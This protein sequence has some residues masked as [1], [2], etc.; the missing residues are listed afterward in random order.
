MVLIRHAEPVVDAHV[1][2]EFWELSGK[3]R[4]D[5]SR[6]ADVL[7]GANL[8]LLV[9]SPEVRAIQTA[10]ILGSTLGVRVEIDTRLHEVRRPW[11]EAHL[12]VDVHRY[13]DGEPVEDWEPLAGVRRRMRSALD[14]ALER[15]RVGYVTHGTAM[16]A[17][18]GASERVDAWTFYRNLRKPDAWRFDDKGARRVRRG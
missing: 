7:A 11:T 13:L 5:V 14:E 18:V 4:R 6:L 8:D 15:G 1:L 16:A 3:G 10:E 12:L 2:P 9:S 17:L